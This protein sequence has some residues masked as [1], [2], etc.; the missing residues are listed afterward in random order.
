MPRFLCQLGESV[1]AGPTHQT[2]VGR[3]EDQRTLFLG[4]DLRW[5][6]PCDQMLLNEVAKTQEFRV[7]RDG[8]M[9]RNN[10]QQKN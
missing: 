1:T 7:L 5:C 3:C 6:D 9:M 8:A 2:L 10:Q 4:H